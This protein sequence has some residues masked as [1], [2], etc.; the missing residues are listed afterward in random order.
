MV[1]ILILDQEKNVVRSVSVESPQGMVFYNDTHTEKV[2]DFDSTF[3]FDVPIDDSDDSKYFQAGN[4]VLLQD[5]D[6][7][8]IL[9]KM[10]EPQ[11][12][13]DDSSNTPYKHIFA[14]NVFIYDL[15]NVIVRD[16]TFTDTTIEPVLNYILAGSGWAVDDV[17]NVGLVESVEFSGYTTA[18]EALHQVCEAFDCEVK[19]Y[20]KTYQGRI[21][22][23]RCKVAA[24]FGENEGVRIENGTGIKGITRKQVITDVK[25][26]LIPLGATQDDGNPLT[27]SSVN[28]GLDYVYDDNANDLYNPGGNGYL[29]TVATNE[30]ITNANALK[31]W[32]KAELKKINSPKY[33]YEV[34]VLMLEQVYGF[35]AHRIRKGSHVRVVDH[36]MNPPVTVDARV[37]ELNISYSDMAKSTCVIGDFIEVNSATP[38]II[39]Q[40]RQNQQVATDAK[41]TAVIAG[42]DAAEAS[43]KAD[44]ASQDA[45]D[46]K[47]K[48]DNAKQ[49]ADQAQE[50][51]NQANNAANQANTA[52]QNA[53]TSANGKNKNYYGIM[54]PVD[55]QEGDR[56][57]KS[58][59]GEEVQTFIYSSGKWEPIT[60]A[61]ENLGTIYAEDGVLGS[62]DAGVI[63][64]GMLSANR[65]G[66]G[67]FTNLLPNPNFSNNLDRWKVN[68]TNTA[69]T[70][71]A[72][73]TNNG[74][75]IEL[76]KTGSDLTQV[77][78]WTNEYI[79]VNPGDKFYVSYFINQTAGISFNGINNMGVYAFRY[80]SDLTNMSGEGM[81]LTRNPNAGFLEGIYT[82]PADVYFLKIQPYHG[83]SGTNAATA[84]TA[85]SLTNIIIRKVTKGTMIEDGTIT[86]DKLNVT[87]LSAISANL[88]T[89]TAGEINGAEFAHDINY[90]VDEGNASG[91]VTI[92]DK[93]FNSIMDM[94]LSFGSTY[95]HYESSIGTGLTIVRDIRDASTPNG[96]N[97]ST[98]RIDGGLINI[99]GYSGHLGLDPSGLNVDH[100]FTLSSNRKLTI[101]HTPSNGNNS[102][103][104]VTSDNTSGV[105]SSLAIYNRTY[106]SA[107]N[108]YV[109]Q[110]G[111]LGRSTSA[112]KYKRFIQPAE[113]AGDKLLNVEGKKWIDKRYVNQIASRM[114]R[115]PKETT[116][117][118]HFDYEVG[119]I[120]EDL[121]EVGLEDYV[122]YEYQPDGSK[123][124]EGIKYERLTV[125]LLDIVKRQQ[126]MLSE[127]DERITKLEAE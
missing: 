115:M 16:R 113:S 96:S 127:L 99:D 34:D 102:E 86:T 29:M 75:G 15:N 95:A 49:S 25:T 26:A 54:E 94:P 24:E 121:A 71:K 45:T 43:Q 111:V 40:L 13:R 73:A 12:V 114:K 39:N 32:G 89:V 97:K 47:Q 1:M 31:D 57:F 37:I 44:A 27:I 66:V 77:S 11:D 38:A 109:T 90:Q 56:W 33:Q 83:T 28:D 51:A 9:F 69:Y 10:T 18:Q 106:S 70:A 91:K 46:A 20:V 126:K 87:S 81:L 107:A 3:E 30:K 61:P 82:V 78:V 65:I 125:P 108:A 8:S 22:D 48:A 119:F 2:V 74:Y 4:Y 50:T 21:I 23:Y 14:E 120:A 92:N 62:V 55:P 53:L 42:G 63:T 19:F 103:F 116:V 93:G 124:I 6:D 112:K 100:T 80:K 101:S 104:N 118:K 52:A 72:I 68:S 59:N 88:G 98:V 41:K 67:D 36:E 58:V 117:A 84:K 110:N 60:L 17:E 35:E 79:P 64:V 5:L 122:V 7:D 85:I 76:A 123:V 105:I